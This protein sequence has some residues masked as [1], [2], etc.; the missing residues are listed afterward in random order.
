MD[1]SDC[2]VGEIVCG[3]CGGYMSVY[4]PGPHYLAMVQRGRLAHGQADCSACHRKWDVNVAQ[5][6]T[7]GA[8]E[9]VVMS[10]LNR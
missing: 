9:I 2:N 10:E 7:T 6:S 4:V 1:I 8:T 3:Y 5:S